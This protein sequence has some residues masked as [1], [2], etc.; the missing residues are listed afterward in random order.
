MVFLCET[1]KKGFV[2]RTVK[3]IKCL[4][5]WEVLNPKGLS[6]GLALGWSGKIQIKQVIATDFCFEVKIVDSDR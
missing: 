1:K 2:K 5:N 3:N 4:T 6:E